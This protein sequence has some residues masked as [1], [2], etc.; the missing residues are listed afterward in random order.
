M[1]AGLINAA[2]FGGASALWLLRNSRN[3]GVDHMNVQRRLRLF[4]PA[5]SVL[6]EQ[7]GTPG[8]WIVG[9]RT[10]DRRTGRRVALWR[11]LTVALL[12]AATEAARRH[13]MPARPEISESEQEDFKRELRAISERYGDDGMRLQE[14]TKRFYE[15]R[16]F[17]PN[18]SRWL[19]AAVVPALINSRLRR[20]LAPTV[21]VVWPPRPPHSP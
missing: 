14:A 5:V 6:G 16:R 17:E 13:L 7:L 21:V 2:I 3:A 4:A 12:K 10:V 20:R 19:A 8:G 15:Q 1:L 9:L 11:T 18:H